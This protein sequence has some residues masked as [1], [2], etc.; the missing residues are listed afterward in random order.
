[1][2]SMMAAAVGSIGTA[3]D[4]IEYLTTRQAGG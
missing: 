4:T 2:I 3:G 1:M